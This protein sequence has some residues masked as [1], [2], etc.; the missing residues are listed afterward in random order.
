MNAVEYR[1]A[2]TLDETL[3]LLAQDPGDTRILAGGTDLLVEMRN[4]RRGPRILVDPKGVGELEE[5]RYDPAEGLTI[6]AL[7]T[8]RTLEA[9][10]LIRSRFRGLAAAAASLGSCQI[11]SRATVGGNLCNASPAADMAP[12]LIGLG[13]RARVLSRTGERWVPLE[14]F[15]TGPGQTVLR[16][17]ELLASLHIPGPA[18]RG[19]CRYI[20][21][22]IRRAMD[23]AIVGVAVALGMEDGNRCAD[24]RIALGAAGPVPIRAK[25]AEERLVGQRLDDRSIQEASQIAAEDARPISDIRASAG[26]RREMVRVLT[27]RTI[28]QIRDARDPQS[29]R[30]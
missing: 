20:K 17:G 8:I 4:R 12:S 16:D 29:E 27:E 2:K 15:F 10:P 13:A 24:I 26:Y 7:V 18:P 6:G 9:S 21:H 22:S 30:A 11:R 14:D 5:L 19:E 23:L 28:R 25:R 3:E 1:R